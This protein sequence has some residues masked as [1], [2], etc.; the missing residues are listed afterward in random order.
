MG[1]VVSYD[2]RLLPEGE[3]D[4]DA[5]RA[6]L[7]AVEGME[8]EGDELAWPRRSLVAQFLLVPE[9]LDV[10]VV[11]TDG[12]EEVRAREFRELLEVLL[13]LA[14]K[15]DARLEDQQLGRDLTAADVNEAV[16]GFA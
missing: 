10:G 8:E 16:S 9:E 3:L 4:L 2:L 12:G 7:L 5:A 1:R 15:L 13:G 11:T 6:A 14:E